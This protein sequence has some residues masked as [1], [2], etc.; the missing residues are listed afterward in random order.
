MTQQRGSSMIL[1]RNTRFRVVFGDRF[2][3]KMN[4]GG[5]ETFPG[6][7]TKLR[8]YLPVKRVD[9]VR[10]N[11]VNHRWPGYYNILYATGPNVPLYTD[12]SRRQKQWVHYG[13]RGNRNYNSL[14]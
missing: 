2:P 14:I 5:R 12:E 8:F 9:I 13:V 11:N 7:V 4:C 6:R 10:G 3:G 1:L